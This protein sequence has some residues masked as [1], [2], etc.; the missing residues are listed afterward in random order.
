MISENLKVIRGRIESACARAGRDPASVR[1][2]AVTKT[3]GIDAVKTLVEAGVT[4]I[5]ENRV[6]ELLFKKERLAHDAG[7]MT[8][9]R[10]LRWHLIGHLQT[11]K[12]RQA[13]GEV[14]LVHSVDSPRL[15]EEIDRRAAQQGAPA[16]VLLEV[17]IARE[18]QKHGFSPEALGEDLSAIRKLSRLDIQGL[19]T[20]PPLT[21]DPEKSRPHFRALRELRDRLQEDLHLPLPE[22]SMGMS[23]DY[24][25]AVEEGA[26]LLRIGR[27]LFQQST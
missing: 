25:V 5:G 27:A 12:V 18:P 11:N 7:H 19:M 2:V 24:E 10:P 9:D 4:D 23:Q 14:D 13:A 26:T 8:H 20:M 6:K 16:S 17:N 22:L 1:L 3:V 15:A 21:D